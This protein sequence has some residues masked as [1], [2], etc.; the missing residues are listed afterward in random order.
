MLYLKQIIL[1][2]A[3]NRPI[4]LSESL[5]NMFTVEK[6]GDDDKVMCPKCQRKTQVRM[7]TLP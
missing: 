6:L 5:T 2:T 1:P 7:K 3:E 4:C